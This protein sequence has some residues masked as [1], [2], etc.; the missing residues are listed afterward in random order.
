ML[1]SNPYPNHQLCGLPLLDYSPIAMSHP[2]GVQACH[3]P[4][5]LGAQLC[6]AVRGLQS[7]GRHALGP[8]SHGDG[9]LLP[10]PPRPA[11]KHGLASTGA[12]RFAWGSLLAYGGPPSVPA[13]RACKPAGV[14]AP[15]ST[16]ARRFAWGSLGI[17]R[18][19]FCASQACMQACR[20]TGT[21]KHGRTRAAGLGTHDHGAMQ[22]HSHRSICRRQPTHLGGGLGMDALRMSSSSVIWAQWSSALCTRLVSVLVSRACGACGEDG[23]VG[24]KRMWVG[25]SA[26]A[27]SAPGWCRSMCSGPVEGGPGRGC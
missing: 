2:S 1:E 16:G 10:A 7:E 22:A 19:P 11:C 12:R 8:G 21:C 24:P 4:Q 3:P 6:L 9:G 15:A 18:A 26:S 17:W 23:W 20:C 13:R 25:H 14:R 5:G 27:R